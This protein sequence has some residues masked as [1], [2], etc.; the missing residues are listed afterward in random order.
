MEL[1]LKGKRALVTGATRGIGRAIAEHLLNEGVDLAICARDERAVADAVESLS[2]IGPKVI[3]R[4]VDIADTAAQT[5]WIDFAADALGGLDI[6][7]P[8][9]SVGGGP[10][11]WQSAF[12]IDVMGTV[13]GCEAVIPHMKAVSGGSIVMI[14]TTAAFEVWRA[15]QA[16]G[17]FKAGMINYAK[18]LSDQLAPSQIRV[19]TVAPGPVYFSGGA[20][21]DIETRL[22][23]FF[24]NTL[25]SIP[26]GRMGSPADIARAVVFLASGASSYITGITITVDGGRTRKVDY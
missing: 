24:K 21:P 17:V 9:V 12:E 14:A 18:N 20:W 1:H 4:A 26:M 3:G 22:P 15:P 23:E 5:A 10:E 16:Y 7:I 8:C 11:K 6:F 25:D 19:N 2:R 13:R